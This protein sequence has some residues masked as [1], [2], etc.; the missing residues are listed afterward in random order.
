MV[1]YAQTSSSVPDRYTVRSGARD[2]LPNT[3]DHRFA[4]NGAA[5]RYGGRNAIV[6]QVAG[7]DVVLRRFATRRRLARIDPEAIERRAWRL[8][9]GAAGFTTHP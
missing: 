7:R 8:I 1:Q 3:A 4:G 2:R 5:R 9:G 6:H